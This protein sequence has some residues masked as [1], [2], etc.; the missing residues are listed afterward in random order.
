MGFNN[1]KIQDFVNLFKVCA[2]YR[3]KG[4]KKKES[5]PKIANEMDNAKAIIDVLLSTSFLHSKLPQEILNQKVG[6][7]GSLL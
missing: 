4:C 5:E 2:A 7:E 6:L 3:K 1:R